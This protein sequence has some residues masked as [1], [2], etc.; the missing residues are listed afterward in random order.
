MDRAHTFLRVPPPAPLEPWIDFIWY[1]EGTPPA[2]RKESVIAG[3]GTGLILNLCEDRVRTY[4]GPGYASERS[5]RGIAASG[6]CTQ[7]FAIDAH[8]PEIMGAS[9][10]PG[11]ARALLGV[12]VSELR[13]LHVALED[14]L[15]AQAACIHE[16][17]V[18]AGTPMLRIRELGRALLALARPHG[19]ASPAI[20]HALE[21]FGAHPIGLRVANVARDLGMSHRRFIQLFA[22]AAGVSPKLYLRLQRFERLRAALWADGRAGAASWADLAQDHGYSD[23]SHLIR[24]FREF[25]GLT[26]VAYLARRG[27]GENHNVVLDDAGA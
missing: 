15:G 18:E 8:Q 21:L 11:G 5:L 7:H 26:P 22:D 4:H 14:L 1:W 25:A 6:P 27:A 12:P 9:F 3:A 10:R 23:Q 16:R 2:H 24:D 17:V 13:D 19:A 20:L